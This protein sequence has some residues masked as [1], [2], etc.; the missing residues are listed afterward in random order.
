MLFS[1]AFRRAVGYGSGSTPSFFGG[2]RMT[3]DHRLECLGWRVTDEGQRA[4]GRYFALAKSCDQFVIAF[5]D[6]RCEAWSAA[7][8]P[9]AKRRLACFAAISLLACAQLTCCSANRLHETLPSVGLL[10]P[11]LLMRQSHPAAR[12]R[13]CPK[14]CR[15]IACFAALPSRIPALFYHTLGRITQG[16][17]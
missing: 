5:A 17:L 1:L 3:A 13:T 9:L 8:F 12:F 11:F 4:D 15:A 2:V 10:C 6:T 7:C 14:P 16:P